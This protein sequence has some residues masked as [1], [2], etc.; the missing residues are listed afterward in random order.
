M[1]DDA[2]RKRESQ[3]KKELQKREQGDSKKKAEEMRSA[4]W[5]N[6]SAHSPSSLRIRS[7]TSLRPPPPTFLTLPGLAG[8]PTAE[9]PA[10]SPRLAAETTVGAGI[11][12]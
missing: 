10:A 12:T 6:G 8:P 2:S 1:E 5:Y 4:R 3:N 9:I 11:S 7:L